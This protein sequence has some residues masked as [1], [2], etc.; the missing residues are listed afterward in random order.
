[1]RPVLSVALPPVAPAKPTTAGD[2]GIRPD[3]VDEL[4]HQVRHAGEGRVLA[5]IGLAEDEAGILLREEALGDDDVEKP[6]STISASVG[7]RVMN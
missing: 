7:S 1:M 4:P 6:V 5:R 3:L 2:R